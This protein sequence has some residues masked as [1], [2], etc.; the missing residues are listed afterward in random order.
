MDMMHFRQHC[1]LT[2]CI[3]LVELANSVS[4]D[5]IQITILI[6]R[7]DALS[8]LSLVPQLQLGQPGHLE[9]MLQ[10]HLADAQ[11]H[12]QLQH[13]GEVHRQ[14]CV[15]PGEDPSQPKEDKVDLHLQHLLL[16][17]LHPLLVVCQ[18]HH[19]QEQKLQSREA[20]LQINSRVP[21]TSNQLNRKVYVYH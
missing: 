20:V 4:D 14:P 12:L 19:H 17:L 1:R 13:Q 9:A 15:H 3:E 7:R 2:I 8:N 10:V 11:D 16:L 5:K 6:L 18:R 21:Q